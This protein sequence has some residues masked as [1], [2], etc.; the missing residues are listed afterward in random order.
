VFDMPAL[1]DQLYRGYCRAR[2]H[3][4]EKQLLWR[5]QLTVKG[6]GDSEIAPPAT[7]VLEPSR[8]VRGKVPTAGK[9]T[10][11]LTL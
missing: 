9:S 10:T 4:M 1:F 2:L 6:K 3:E 11:R 8:D 7:L 5:H